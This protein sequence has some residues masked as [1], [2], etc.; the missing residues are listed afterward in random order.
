MTGPDHEKFVGYASLCAVGALSVSERSDFERHVEL[1]RPCVDEVMSLL[2]VAHGLVRAAPQR[3]PPASLR[4]RVLEQVTG[5]KAPRAKTDTARPSDD[6][7]V[8][9]VRTNEGRGPRRTRGSRVGSMLF[10][11]AVA[12]CLVAA[13]GLGWVAADLLSRNR[14]LQQSLEAEVLRA[15]RTELEA[16]TTRE[17]A[18][19]AEATAAIVTAPDVV[20]IALAGQPVAPQAIGRAFWSPSRGLVFTAANLPAL[21]A[22]RV[23]Q[24]W[25]VAPNN[26]IS[27][28]LLSLDTQGRA[29]TTI[30]VPANLTAP[31]TLAVTIE[32]AAGVSAPT[33]ERY[34]VGHP[35]RPRPAE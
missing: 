4:T 16:Q 27:A 20:P 1:C 23:Y 35:P 2:P 33:G 28:G 13:A 15:N 25:F 31:V 24:L 26:P 32:P 18:T 8:S 17:A 3:E 21:P 10:G 14:A 30:P 9:P 19:R 11:L 12:A 6:S 5:K 34:L 7:P 22:D 29:S